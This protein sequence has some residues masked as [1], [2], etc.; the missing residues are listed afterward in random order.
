MAKVWKT[1]VGLFDIHIDPMGEE[2]SSWT[3]AK[4]FLRDFQ[5]DYIV[6]GG[7]TCSVDSI[8]YYNNRKPRLAEGRR[9]SDDVAATRRQLRLVQK[10]NPDARYYYLIGNHEFRV[11]RYID[12]NPAMEGTMDWAVDVGLRSD[13]GMDVV[14]FNRVL[15]I[16]KV[17][18]IHGWYWT[19]NHAKKT[20]LQYGDNIF[21]GHVHEHQV[22]VHNY[23]AE[24]SG[25]PTMAMSV[26]CLS[27]INPD[28]R[29]N[30][31]TRFQ[32]GLL[33]IDLHRDGTFSPHHVMII[34]GVL[35]Y[36]GR[37]WRA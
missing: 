26:G 20:V 5:P 8:S 30:M 34:N 7:D 24:E 13:F 15:R 16:G 11:Q 33:I 37:T 19:L 23:Q 6:F 22:A 9:Y 25:L 35:S 1:L 27:A 12:E 14:E 4:K 32:N 10:Y 28:Y 3:V 36:G 17:S 29:L 31:P 18:I 2:H 21:Y